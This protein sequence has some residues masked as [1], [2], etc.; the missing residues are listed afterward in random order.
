[1]ALKLCIHGH[2]TGAK[3]CGRCQSRTTTVK[4]PSGRNGLSTKKK[5]AVTQRL[6][7]HGIVPVKD[8]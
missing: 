6:R 3:H 1:M 2:L 4:G 5:R 7:D 8:L